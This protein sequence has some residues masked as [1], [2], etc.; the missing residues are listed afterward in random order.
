MPGSTT[1][2]PARSRGPSSLVRSVDEGAHRRKHGPPTRRLRRVTADQ[3]QPVLGRPG[4]LEIDGEGI[5]FLRH[6]HA[7]RHAGAFSSRLELDLS[8][9]GNEVASGEQRWARRWRGV[10]S[11]GPGCPWEELVAAD[12]HHQHRGGGGD[13]LGVGIHRVCSPRRPPRPALWRRVHLVEGAQE[14]ALGVLVRFLPKPRQ[15]DARAGVAFSGHR[16]A[17]AAAGRASASSAAR[18]ARIA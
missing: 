11:A 2:T 16:V 7:T 9:D 5:V 12:R 18:M 13:Q 1:T 6:R 8:S 17:S 14:H 3:D 15:D 10:R 4:A